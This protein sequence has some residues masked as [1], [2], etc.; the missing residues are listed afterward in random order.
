MVQFNSEEQRLAVK[1]ALIRVTA[2]ASWSVICHLVEEAV[3]ELEQKSLQEDDEEKARTFRHDARGARKF[4]GKLLKLVEL[5][6]S[7]DAD[8]GEN[9]LEVI[10]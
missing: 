6:K 10:M 5:A 2:D 8:A 3:Y 4:W 1:A 7:V 9:F